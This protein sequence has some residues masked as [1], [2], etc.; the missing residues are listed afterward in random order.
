MAFGV[1]WMSAQALMPA[2]IGLAIDRG[3]ALQDLGA[4]LRTVS[5]V[6]VLDIV[7]AGSG[8]TRLGSRPGR[9]HYFF[10][11]IAIP[12]VAKAKIM[13]KVSRTSRS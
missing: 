1:L 6:L 2:L 3:V 4:L 11:I 13:A 10:E 5:L 7:Q 9:W 12:L 8:V